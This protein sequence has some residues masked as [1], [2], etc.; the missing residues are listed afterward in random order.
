MLKYAEPAK[1]DDIKTVFKLIKHENIFEFEVNRLIEL[2][3]IS[4][5][6]VTNGKYVAYI[7]INGW[8]YA[9]W[10]YQRKREKNE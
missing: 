8:N 7:N 3:F 6:R 1:C 10:F 9:K 2:D 5:Y 4:G